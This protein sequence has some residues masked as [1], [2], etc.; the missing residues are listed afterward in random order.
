MDVEE[1][2]SLNYGIG[3]DSGRPPDLASNAIFVEMDPIPKRAEFESRAGGKGEPHGGL[4]L[5]ATKEGVAMEVSRE[6]CKVKEVI[7]I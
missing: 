6:E 7:S 2:G 5:T 1:E 3:P 4:P